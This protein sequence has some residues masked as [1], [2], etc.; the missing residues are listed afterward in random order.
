MKVAS[1]DRSP[2]KYFGKYHHLQIVSSAPILQISIEDPSCYVRAHSYDIL[3][4]ASL[5]S[6]HFSSS[7]L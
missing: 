5:D 3:V 2:K 6:D 4:A 7:W 1:N